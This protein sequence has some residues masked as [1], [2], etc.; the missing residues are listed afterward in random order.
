[1]AATIVE[2]LAEAKAKKEGC[3]DVMI[4]I[5]TM[6]RPPNG[7]L[8]SVGL[9]R[10]NRHTGEMGRDVHLAIKL[11]T[12]VKVGMKLD[13]STVMWWAMQE[14]DAGRALTRGAD[15][16]RLQLGTLRQ[17]FTQHD[18]VWAK[19]RNFDLVILRSAYNLLNMAC[20]FKEEQ[21]SCMSKLI[22]TA[23]KK[24]DFVTSVERSGTH[25]NALD[26]AITQAEQLTDI[27]QNT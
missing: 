27:T 22:K 13:P 16:I 26:D 10:F 11:D 17:Y 9:V 15:D 7:A 24:H 18:T 23:K 21:E 8:C 19:P 4:D 3:F 14:A 20:P 6:G 2:A 25:H 12:A 5:E 1:M